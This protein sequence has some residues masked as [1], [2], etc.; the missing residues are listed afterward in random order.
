MRPL[1]YK[2]DEERRKAQNEAGARCYQKHRKER[3]AYA[4]E[5]VIRLKKEGKCPWKN[6]RAHRLRVCGL[7]I[8]GIESQIKKQN[9]LCDLCFEPMLPYGG[10]DKNSAVPD[11]DHSTNKFR[12]MIHRKCNSG[13]G[14]L[15]DSID[16]LH[17]ALAYLEK[18]QCAS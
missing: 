3:I 10:L 5:R 8:E 4:H 13:I 18:H 9:N 7:T 11:H 12:A 2:T 1:K 15:G 16:R 14:L 6:Q 17:K